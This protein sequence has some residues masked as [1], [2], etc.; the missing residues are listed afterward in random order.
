MGSRPAVAETSVHLS[1]EN[2]FE[3]FELF[4]DLRLAI[5]RDSVDAKL[6]LQ[7]IVRNA[8]D[9]SGRTENQLRKARAK[10]RPRQDVFRQKLRRSGDGSFRGSLAVLPSRRAIKPCFD[11]GD[12]AG[13][14]KF[15][16]RPRL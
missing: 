10:H 4:I 2:P 15:P 9:A 5:S 3:K 11:S 14:A 6:Q 12:S 16:P 8:D 1:Y 13:R 7:R